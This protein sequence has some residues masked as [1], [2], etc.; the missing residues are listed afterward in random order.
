MPWGKAQQRTTMNINISTE[1]L[2]TLIT[3][4][5]LRSFTRAAQVLNVTQ[6][7][8]SA[9][10]K[11]LQV[12]L[13]G[14]LFDKSAPGVTLTEKG[15]MVVRQARNMLSI[16]DRILE[17]AAAGRTLDRLRVGM[18]VDCCEESLHQALAS[19]RQRYRS[20]NVHV[21]ADFCE[22]LM[23]DFHRGDYDVV[24]AHTDAS[25]AAG[26][27]Y[28]WKEELVWAAASPEMFERSGPIPMVTREASSSHRLGLAMLEQGGQPYD[29]VYVGKTFR[30][31]VA[32]VAAGEGVTCWSRRVLAGT[33][34]AV[35]EVSSTL[36]RLPPLYGGIF[37]RDPGER[38]EAKELGD[39]IAAAV[40]PTEAPIYAVA[41]EISA[42]VMSSITG[43]SA[44]EPIWAQLGTVP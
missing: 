37:L 2:R 34:L 42:P 18:P 13:G 22:T 19:F 27:R 8:V 26:A 12:L 9:Q 36:P 25:R 38:S 24:Y 15:H 20:L 31:V 3:V 16:N 1:L 7:A 11:R 14:D 32:A 6:P 44:P 28:A 10:M 21:Q 23:R 17:F 35:C 33:T 39:A 43:G 30:G 40:L 4:V 29:I 41:Q 5:E